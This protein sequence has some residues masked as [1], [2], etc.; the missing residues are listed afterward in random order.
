MT[1][2]S[3][4]L[5]FVPGEELT[6]AGTG[7][8]SQP[9]QPALQQIVSAKLA[10]HRERRSQQAAAEAHAA[11]T[12]NER[13]P[14]Q[15]HRAAE[16][17]A[18][19]YAQTPTYRAFL[20]DEAK[21]AIQQAAAAAEVA[22]RNAE[23]VAIAQHHLLS[24]LGRWTAPQEFSASTADTL[25]TE[26]VAPVAARR[27][28]PEASPTSTP[29]AA[30]LTVRLYEDL[31]KVPA[32]PRP[33]V[34]TPRA[35]AAAARANDFESPESLALDAEIAFRQ[36]PV[37]EDFG[38]YEPST[39]LPANLLEFPRQ[40]VAARRARPVLAEG[41]LLEED[42]PRTRQLRIFEVEPSLIAITPAPPLPAAEWSS[43][44]LDAHTVTEHV[45]DPDS[46]P[47]PLLPSLLPPQTA[48]I[49]L[50]MMAALVDGI[51]VLFGLVA[52]AA[53]AAHFAG[54]I[55]LGTPTAIVAAGALV[56]LYLLYQVLFF[57]LNGQTPGM[58]YARIGLCTFTDENPTR[59]A[60]RRRILA[61]CVAAVPLGIGLLWALLDDD[62]LGWHDRIS[63]MY[64]RAY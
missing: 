18:E 61:Q 44:R 34:S 43:I 51:L 26:P 58:S 24:E 17:V 4:Q 13:A 28:R 5:D 54:S 60:M 55:P 30:G 21:R 38:V 50:R 25:T 41:P 52:F 9:V 3:A 64:Q 11:R 49:G 23:A 62:S 39:P 7:A 36:A 1:M 12:L 15:R 40:L 42:L 22:V 53:V 10:A 59:A 14:R 8:A 32:T 2:G 48:P 27:P 56:T 35:H 31:R 20:A 29:R 45:P 6:D 46:L 19:R 37:F 63:R 33:E 16:A 57:S 47:M